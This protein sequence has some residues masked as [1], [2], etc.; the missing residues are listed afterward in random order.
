MQEL[1]CD[2]KGLLPLASS[3]FLFLWASARNEHSKVAPETVTLGAA[4]EHILQEHDIKLLCGDIKR[5][6]AEFR[7]LLLFKSS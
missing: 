3:G 2:L 7:V 6:T 5:R 1:L 4:K